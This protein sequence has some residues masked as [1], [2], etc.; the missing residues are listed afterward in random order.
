[1]YYH[2]ELA[3]TITLNKGKCAG[4]A[5]GDAGSIPACESKKKGEAHR[6]EVRSQKA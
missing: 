1:M 2:E 3:F 6:P 4:K 5:T